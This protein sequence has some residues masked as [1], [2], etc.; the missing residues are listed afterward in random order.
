MSGQKLSA[1]K[2][3]LIMSRN[4]EKTAS[5]YS[6]IVGLKIV[7]STPTFAE[8]LAQNSQTTITIRK[9]PTLAHATSGF[10]PVL[11]FDLPLTQ[12]DSNSNL[13]DDGTEKTDQSLVEFNELLEKAKSFYG[14]ELD[15][16]VEQ[17]DY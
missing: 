10:S 15:G 7:H 16:D 5:F 4:V 9:T 8:L 1:F 17:D 14:C 11:V 13:A 2:G 3:V 6:E 12:S